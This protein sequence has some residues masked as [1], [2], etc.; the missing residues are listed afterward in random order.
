MVEAPA[1]LGAIERGGGGH[2]GAIENGVDLERAHQL[3]RVARDEAGQIRPDLG[4]A[5][6]RDLI[7]AGDLRRLQ[8]VVHE[9][10]DLIFHLIGR[11]TVLVVQRHADAGTFRSTSRGS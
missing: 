8:I 6:L 2:I 4:K 10:S 9:A 11:Q 1:A 3:M 7:F 5:P